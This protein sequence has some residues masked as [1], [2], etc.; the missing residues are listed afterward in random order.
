MNIL[1]VYPKYPDTFW[2]FKHALKFVSKK[3]AN[4]P[5]GL[6]TV[7]SLLPLIWNKRLV[8]MNIRSL[9]VRD[10]MWADMIFIGAM[11]L[12][13]ESVNEVVEICKLYKKTI[14]AGGPLFTEE[15]EKY[16]DIDHLILNE[17]EISLP[18]FLIDLQKGSERHI[19][20]TEEYADISASPI[21][22]YSLVKSSEYNTLSIQYTRGC[23]FN[24]EFCDITALLGHKVRYKSPEQI[25]AELNNIYDYGWRKSVFFVD[26]NFIGNIKEIKRN[27]LPAIIDWM[28]AHD[29]PFTFTT[30]ASINLSDDNELLEMMA[31][32][33][34]STIFI[35]IETTDKESL[36][37][38]GK[39]Q[40]NNRD[41]LKSIRKIQDHGIEVTGGFIVG[42]DHDKSSVFRNQVEFIQSSGI[43]SAMVGLLG[44]PKKTK[45]YKRLKK[46]GRLLREISG[47]NTDLS[48]NFIPKMNM[49]ELITGYKGIIRGI[50]SG[51]SYYRRVKYF[52]SR[53]EPNLKHRNRINPAKIFAFIRSFFVLGIYDSDRRNY[54]KLVGWCFFNRPK[55]VPL[56][57]T[58][59]VYGY[60]FRK[61]FREILN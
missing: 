12:Q 50:Y 35:G 22:D 4:P 55:L 49:D 15:P 53:F 13:K 7:A 44:A 14:V 45:L 16:T 52:L 54:W 57:I 9:K 10:I 41:M 61:I 39:K 51:N 26:D 19:Y 46:E 21:P 29:Y 11:N 59:S 32:A 42:F 24:C 47:N 58:Y 34:F 3:A 23:P 38:C 2:S 48:I 1:L 20:K 8:D 43:I 31:N 30:E 40:N 37:E 33:G 27:L 28:E 17:A 18:P 36:A 6:L 60:H 5:L 25:L 56:A